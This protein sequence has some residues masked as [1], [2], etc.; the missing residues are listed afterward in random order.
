MTYAEYI[1]FGKDCPVDIQ[2]ILPQHVGDKSSIILISP[3]GTH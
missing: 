3:G 1:G 2:D